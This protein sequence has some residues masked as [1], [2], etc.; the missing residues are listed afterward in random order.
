MILIID[1]I[2]MFLLFF[3]LQ[4]QTFQDEDESNRHAAVELFKKFCDGTF[5][6]EVWLKM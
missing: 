4:V 3:F 5:L 2:L 1:R 6:H